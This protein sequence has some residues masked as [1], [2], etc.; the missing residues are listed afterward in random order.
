MA[1]DELS[2]YLDEIASQNELDLDQRRTCQKESSVLLSKYYDDAVSLSARLM[3]GSKKQIKIFYMFWWWT[4]YDG[5][6]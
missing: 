6:C 3:N 2:S 4:R 5:G 1:K